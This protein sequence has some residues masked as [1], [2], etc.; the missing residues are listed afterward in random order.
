MATLKLRR[1]SE[2][3]RGLPKDLPPRLRSTEGDTLQVV[4]T[5]D[6]FRSSAMTRNSSGRWRWRAR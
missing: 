3:G 5:P 1:R 4:E 2:L 6:G